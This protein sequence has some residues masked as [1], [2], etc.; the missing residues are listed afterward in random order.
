[1]LE[2]NSVQNLRF[3]MQNFKEHP[4]RNQPDD[5]P[6]ELSEVSGSRTLLSSIVRESFLAGLGPERINRAS[7]WMRCLF[8]QRADSQQR[9]LLFFFASQQPCPLTQ[10]R[11][12]KVQSISKASDNQEIERKPGCWH[13][14]SPKPREIEK[15]LPAEKETKM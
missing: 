10:Y 1:M 11:S 15:C 3:C 12:L 13:M 7:K 5:L 8:L 14:L 6:V 2:L 9:A 4:P